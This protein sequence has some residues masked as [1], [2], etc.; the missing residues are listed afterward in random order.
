MHLTPS[1]L[2]AALLL[3]VAGCGPVVHDL[4]TAAG[5]GA[6]TGVVGELKKPDDQVALSD[7]AASPGAQRASQAV[8]V[9]LARG[10]VDEG[11]AVVTGQASIDAVGAR[12]AGLDPSTRPTPQ[13]ADEVRGRVMA[14]V[15]QDVDPVVADV[16]RSAVR[17]G[18]GEAA[19][20]QSQ[21]E[22]DRVVGEA[23]RTAVRQGMTEALN[24]QSQADAHA[25]AQ[26]VGDGATRGIVGAVR[27]EVGPDLG[28]FV[29]DQVGPAV[30]DVM[31]NDVRPALRGLFRDDIGPAV[32]ET[33]RDHVRPALRD[34]FH[35]DIAP[36]VVQILQES[37][38]NALKVPVRPDVQPAVIKNAS[39]L[40][41]GASYG[42]NQGMIDLGVLAPD[43]SL[44][45]KA[46][47][48]LWGVVIV[49]LLAG[50]VAVGF[51][52]V[53]TILAVNLRRGRAT[54]TP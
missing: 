42:S 4:G 31:V 26:T 6:A 22:L 43:G 45:F 14:F 33:M 28:R 36:T 52:I 15:Q 16:V 44:K 51:L 39:N 29:H 9:G 34:F 25:M 32:D 53:L 30:S 5:A 10:L 48:F 3:A 19:T 46:R 35:D 12:A 40:S 37:A 7:V 27:Q 18:L 54:R 1:R 21:A 38:A 50:L 41:L 2:A 49:V 13:S 8:G 17:Q 20:P 24:P 11:A 47:A 23:V